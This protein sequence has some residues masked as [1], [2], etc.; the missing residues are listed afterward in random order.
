MACAGTQCAIRQGDD[1]VSDEE[2]AHASR[3]YRCHDCSR[4]IRRGELYFNRHT[5]FTVLCISCLE[6]RK[7]RWAKLRDTEP[8]K[9]RILD[10]LRSKGPMSSQDLREKY[11]TS[12]LSW[13]RQLKAA[14]YP[15]MRSRAPSNHYVYY[16]ETEAQLRQCDDCGRTYWAAFVGEPPR[17]QRLCDACL[18][19]LRVKMP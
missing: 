11:G 10:D 12:F 18:H 7:E 5:D 4:T 16:L 6:I 15:I 8:I 3:D 19:R 9:Q 1:P 2:L 14:G 17:L 13:I